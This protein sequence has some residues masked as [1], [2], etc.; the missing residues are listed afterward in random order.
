MPLSAS[1][2]FN[3]YILLLLYIPLCLLSLSISI[4]L[5][6]CI[7]R[8]PSLSI[9]LTISFLISLLISL[10]LCPSVSIY[11]F[12]YFTASVS[13]YTIFKLFSPL[14]C[15]IFL[16]SFSLLLYFKQAPGSSPFYITLVLLPLFLSLYARSLSLFL[17]WHNFCLHLSTF[18]SLMKTSD[19]VINSLYI[20]ISVLL[21]TER[22]GIRMIK[23]TLYLY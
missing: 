12:L 7:T 3:L 11:L 13:L 4:F 23:T 16:L 18:N 22:L 6:L 21:C 17:I 20:K 19:I 5:S 9:S 14:V 10:S 2:S 8:H 15:P 1:Y